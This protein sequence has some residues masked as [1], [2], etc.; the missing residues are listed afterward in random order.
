MKV[1]KG[2]LDTSRGDYFTLGR[3][4]VLE[5]GVVH[6]WGWLYTGK[7]NTYAVVRHIANGYLG[8]VPEGAR[9]RRMPGGKPHFGRKG[10][11]FSLS[12]TEGRVLAAF[13]RFSVGLDME[14]EGRSVPVKKIARRCFHA[15]ERLAL[16]SCS[17]EI[18]QKVFLRMWVRKEAAVKLA[19]EGIA[20]GLRK[21]NIETDVHP[22]K[23]YRKE[24]RLHVREI[25]PWTG[26]VG[27]L[28]AEC[29]FTVATFQTDG[30]ILHSNLATQSS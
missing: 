12:H 10:L 13:A 15:S 27:A 21:I 14:K 4:P 26:I 19:G 20:S 28:A 23:V 1:R 24:R 3:V 7:E 17:N 22:W 16:E 6:L 29:R 11:S 9:L 18:R 2:I 8:S 5:F 30:D 25:S